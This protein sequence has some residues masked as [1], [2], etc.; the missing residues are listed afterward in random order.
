M[1]NIQKPDQTPVQ[2]NREQEGVVP[3]TRIVVPANVDSTGTIRNFVKEAAQAA[4]LDRKRSYRLQL[5]VD[6]IAT[7]IVKY[8]FLEPGRDGLI[9]VCS[10]LTDEELVITLDDT[11][12]PFDP[13][14]LEAPD[15]LETPLEERTIGGYGVYLTMKNVDAFHYEFVDGHNRNIFVIKRNS[16]NTE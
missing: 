5:A 3:V 9:E 16:Q 1:E 14:S 8:G 2:A 12:D 4:G 13:M 15:D 10:D 7:N 11:S 6:E